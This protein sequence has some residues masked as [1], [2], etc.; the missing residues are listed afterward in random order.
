MNTTIKKI[1]MLA[2]VAIAALL[3]AC[4]EDSTGSSTA[5]PTISDLEVGLVNSKVT[6]IGSDLHMDA[7]I[8]AEGTIDVIKVELHPEDG[9]G[10]DIEAEF[11]EYSGLKN[12]TFHKHIDIPATATAGDYHFHLIVIDQEGNST[13]AEAELSI[14]ELVDEEAPELTIES[15]PTSGQSFSTGDSITISVHI[16]DNHELAG[17]FVGLVF[18]SDSIADADVGG[19]NTKVIPMLHTHEFDMHHDE[20]EHDHEEGHDHDH[21]VEAEFTATIVVGAENDN[22]MTPAPIEGDN[23]WKSG[24]YYILVRTKDTAGNWTFSEK[25]PLEINL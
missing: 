9:S 10:V 17:L 16:T 2:A 18:E 11:D 20:E 24:N 7:E 25:Y 6:Y 5:K 15:A 3:S 19:T 12:T 4:G 13:E 21:G 8:V 23:A 22:N 1:F 14:Q